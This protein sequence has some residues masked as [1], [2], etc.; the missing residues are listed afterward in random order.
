M[1]NVR[2]TIIT[3][4]LYIYSSPHAQMLTR[5]R[6]I[7]NRV[8]LTQ[9]SLSARSEKVPAASTRNEPSVGKAGNDAEVG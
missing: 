6:N 7:T 3:T 9:N 1:P 5:R 8:A 2:I 4:I